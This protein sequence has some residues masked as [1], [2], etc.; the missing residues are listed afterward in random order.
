MGGC[1]LLDL[2]GWE[3]LVGSS[4]GILEVARR[5]MMCKTLEITGWYAGRGK[6]DMP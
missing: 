1:G 2:E 5:Y 4:I 3:L 6:A